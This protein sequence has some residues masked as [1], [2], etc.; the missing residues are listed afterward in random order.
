MYNDLSMAWNEPKSINNKDKDKDKDNKDKDNLKDDDTYQDPF[1]RNAY[2]NSNQPNSPPDLEQ[3]F[4]NLKKQLLEFLGFTNKK[5][6]KPNNSNFKDINNPYNK[7]QF[8]WGFII[9][10]LIYLFSGFYIVLPAEQAVITRFGKFNR[11]VGQGPHWLLRFVEDKNIVNDQKVDSNKHSAQMLTKDENIVFIEI[12]VQYRVVNAKY[13]LFQVVD[14]INT[15]KQAVE[16][17]MRQVVGH[18][19]LDFIMTDGR[20][21]ISMDI[22]DQVATI[23]EQYNTGIEVITVALKEAKAPDAVK[24]A[25]DD[26]IKAREEQER[27]KHAA[28]AFAN[29]IV[30]EAKGDAER[31]LIEA[32]AYQ[33]EVIAKSI[34]DT[35]RFN[36]ILNEYNKAP[37]VTKKRLY[38]EALEEVLS[39]S[40]KILIDLKNNNNLVYLPLEK[41]MNNKIA[42]NSEGAN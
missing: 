23:L 25:F 1:K 36:A 42:N 7:I 40:S 29:K 19:N 41:L 11:I 34:G 13:F 14:P 12:E 16:S 38:I 31:M 9:I 33:Q 17:A 10:L 8:K 24:G 15:L 30:P 32:H 3:V 22:Q 4:K 20:N 27:L 35:L 18:S 37:E 6:N 39:N 2:K 5:S 26:V 21:K 28:E